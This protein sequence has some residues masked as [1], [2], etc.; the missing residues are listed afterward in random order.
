[1]KLFKAIL[2]L[3]AALCLAACAESDILDRYAHS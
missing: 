2:A 3:L 1:M